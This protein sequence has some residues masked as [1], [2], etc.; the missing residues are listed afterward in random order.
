MASICGHKSITL[1][2][3]FPHSV[4]LLSPLLAIASTIETIDWESQYVI[5]LWLSVL[6]LAPFDLIAL[7]LDPSTTNAKIYSLCIQGTTTGPNDPVQ[8]AA[9]I[10][11]ARFLSRRDNDYID[12]FVFSES[13]NFQAISQVMKIVPTISNHISQLLKLVDTPHE[14]L[15]TAS[16]TYIG[17]L[18]LVGD[19]VAKKHSSHLDDVEMILHKICVISGSNQ[20]SVIR[21]KGAKAIARIVC[22]LPPEYIGQFVD[23][24]AKIALVE[25]KKIDYEIHFILLVLGEICRRKKTL[26]CDHHFLSL[27]MID[28]ISIGIE[29]ERKSSATGPIRDSACALVWSIARLVGGCGRGNQL[30]TSQLFSRIVPSLL[31]LSLFNFDVN[32]RRTGAAALQELIG[33]VGTI[34]FPQGLKILNLIDFWSVSRIKDSFCVIPIELVTTALDDDS[35]SSLITSSSLIKTFSDHLWNEILFSCHDRVDWSRMNLASNSFSRFLSLQSVEF[36]SE[37]ILQIH[38]LIMEKQ[39]SETTTTCRVV[40]MC[41]MNSI[42]EFCSSQIIAN[43]S[44]EAKSCLRNL[45]PSIEKNRM[46]REKFG[47][48]MRIYCYKYLSKIFKYSQFLEFK[49]E[50]KFLEKIADIINDG[51]V[52]LVADVSVAAC[53][54]LAALS[55]HNPKIVL[56]LIQTTYLTRLSADFEINL[57]ARRG[58]LSA[59]ISV[60]NSMMISDELTNEAI[61]ELAKKEA[62]SWPRH[63]SG[64]RQLV[65]PE[66]RRLAVLILGKFFLLCP[67]IQ[68]I[69]FQCLEDYQTDKRG[70]VGSWVRQTVIEVLSVYNRGNNIPNCVLAHKFER[71]DKIRECVEISI[72]SPLQSMGEVFAKYGLPSDTIVGAKQCEVSLTNLNLS[73]L[74]LN[75]DV[76]ET[77]FEIF[78]SQI[79]VCVGSSTPCGITECVQNELVDICESS[80]IVCE[81]IANCLASF[82]VERKYTGVRFSGKIDAINRLVIPSLNTLIL[83]MQTVPLT[84]QFIDSI[85]LCS[86]LS[87]LMD[88]LNL[89]SILQVTLL[90]TYSKFITSFD[91]E[92]KFLQTFITRILLSEIPLVRVAGAV[93]LTSRWIVDT[94]DELMNIIEATNWMCESRNEWILSVKH[95]ANFFDLDMNNIQVVENKAGLS[96]PCVSHDHKEGYAQFIQEEYRLS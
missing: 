62:V 54:A 55:S 44:G 3:V 79:I 94:N 90:K 65:D 19:F 60:V 76:S 18:G 35:S 66:C 38:N 30:I 73:Q 63:F 29:K 93:D 83:L 52:H 61:V 47:D 71:M 74:I 89:P 15:Y 24:F 85:T 69:L 39:Q 22:K 36:L 42:L 67:N 20:S 45:I 31:T 91:F 49:N 25:A 1:N 95:I 6:L 33:R 21:E 12:H 5:F 53:H 34:L 57:C 37:K 64:N 2:E 48:K 4:R 77:E 11:L 27:Q 96:S 68:N 14:S 72:N 56:K 46:F 41:L 13:L 43:V 17:V 50:T 32:M 8:K 75:D 40:G 70:D 9:A 82:I 7:G 26:N 92:K 84:K 16:K 80:Q 51:I 23:H 28:L 10:A 81:R 86:S 87:D 78:L 59:L 88:E 58:M